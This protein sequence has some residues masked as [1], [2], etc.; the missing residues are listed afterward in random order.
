MLNPFHTPTTKIKSK[1]FDEK[2]KLLAQKY[3]L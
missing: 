3:L 2:V 1:P